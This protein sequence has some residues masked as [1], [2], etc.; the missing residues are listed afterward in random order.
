MTSETN[1][2]HP[3]Q[4]TERPRSPAGDDGQHVRRF[5]ELLS[6]CMEVTRRWAHKVPGFSTLHTPDQDL[7]FYSSFLELFVL[8]L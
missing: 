3:P 8:R 4:F 2:V 1:L 7:L 6:R 5:Y